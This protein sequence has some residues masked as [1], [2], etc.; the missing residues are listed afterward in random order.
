[1][2]QKV[3]IIVNG[4]AYAPKDG[5]YDCK[6]CAMNSECFHF[7]GLPCS[8]FADGQAFEKVEMKLSGS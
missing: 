4:K 1:M 2:E 6:K 8:A 3:I 5:V 7:S